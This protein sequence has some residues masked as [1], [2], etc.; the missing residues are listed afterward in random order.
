MK[1]IGVDTGG[2]FTD[3]VLVDGASVR[4]HKVFSTPDNPARAVKKGFQDLGLDP[5]FLLVH[6]STVATNAFLERKGGKVLLVTTAG[7]E[8]VIEIG[9]QQRPDL[10]ALHVTRPEPLIPPECRFGVRER[11]AADGAVLHSPPDDELHALREWIRSKKPDAVAVVGLFSFI[12]PE[13]ERRIEAALK[14]T[15]VKVFCSSAIFPEYREYERTV[16][17]ALNAYLYPVM[18]RYIRELTDLAGPQWHMM[19]STGGSVPWSEVVDR[20]IQT[21]LSGPVAGVVAARRIGL[22][23]GF[24]RL[25]TLDMGGTSTDVS[26]VDGAI[27]LTQESTLEG[28]PISIPMVRIHTI[29]AGGGSMVWL[30]PGGALRVGPQ[31]AGADPGPAAYDRGGT[32]PTLTDAH[33]VLGHLH[34]EVFLGGQFRLNPEA[35]WQAL[36]PLARES[37]LA[38]RE[39]AE[40]AV[41]IANAQMER[42]LRVISLERGYDPRDFALFAFG[43]AGGLHACSLAEAIGMQT[44]IWPAYAG[45]TSAFGTLLADTIFT[46]SRS[47]LEASDSRAIRQII[48][49][50][51]RSLEQKIRDEYPDLQNLDITFIENIAVRYKGQAYEIIVPF[52]P[53]PSRVRLAFETIHFQRYGYTR[54]GHPI[55]YVSAIV[56]AVLPRKE[57]QLPSF[58]PP[59]PVATDSDYSSPSGSIPVVQR[60]AIQ[61]RTPLQGPAIIIDPTGTFYLLPGWTAELTPQGHLLVRRSR[62]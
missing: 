28:I 35:A 18:H 11:I 40:G 36:R 42:A 44:I 10:Y 47:L 57:I 20:P 32:L 25:L 48:G 59:S 45:V 31:S 60:M 56:Q 12:N 54:T 58:L 51:R 49:E 61:T 43:G 17:T 1:Y 24:T 4:I 14:E 34:P 46:R 19:V 8:D 23:L 9:R 30:D 6:G 50:L 38:I 55:E 62:A 5:P 52:D 53:T 2:T 41:A 21:L 27:T 3:F 13:N 15:G 39:L 7:F 22:D 29:G 26:L 37:N 33:L 16:V